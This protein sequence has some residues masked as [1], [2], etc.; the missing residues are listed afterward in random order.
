MEVKPTVIGGNRAQGVVTAPVC[1]TAQRGVNLPV[2]LPMNFPMTLD[3]EQQKA[4]AQKLSVVNFLEMTRKDVAVL[5]ENAEK[6]LHRTLDGFLSRIDQLESPRLFKLVTQLKD[7]VAKENLAELADHILNGQL[8]W[9]DR[10]KNFLF[11]KGAADAAA[12]AW[13]ET[14]RLVQG[15]TKTL[16]DQVGLME[17][18]LINEQVRL[19]SEIQNMESIKDAYRKSFDDFVISV[20]FT[21]ALLG[22]AKAQ[23]ADVISHS[24]PNNMTHKQ[25]IGELQDKLQALESRALALEGTLTRLPADQLTLRQLQNAAITTLQETTTTASSRFASIKMTLLTIHGAMM[26]KGVQQLASQGAAL[27]ANLQQVRSKLMKDVATTAANAPGDNR[28]AQ[29]QQLRDIV[30]DTENLANI[31]ESA[32]VSNEQKFSQ[33]RAMFDSAR[34][35]MLMQGQRINP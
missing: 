23:V 18:E 27:D 6:S 29:A 35:Q 33:A 22:M 32:R 13:E 4:V 15:K 10:V 3:S 2:V 19:E 25:N 28:L 16:S 7:A 24:D 20:A 14:K 12:Q 17:R 21:G 34:Q 8:G 30:A 1:V 5:E 26:V 11:R 31:V 9:G